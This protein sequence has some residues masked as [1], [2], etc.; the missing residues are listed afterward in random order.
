MV[1]L[2]FQVVAVIAQNCPDLAELNLS[3]TPVTDKSMA[4]LC[5][6]RQT[7]GESLKHAQKLR[8]LVLDDVTVTPE[9]V[10]LVLD[11][12]PRLHDVEYRS[13]FRVR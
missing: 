1:C 4:C 12:L 6:T 2:P 9:G 13:I 11:S 7:N 5:R 3:E 8:R 10:A